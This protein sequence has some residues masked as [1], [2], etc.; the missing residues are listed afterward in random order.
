VDVNAICTGDG[1]F[2]FEEF[3]DAFEDDRDYTNTKNCR[4]RS[5]A[6]VAA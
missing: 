3:L 1:E 2:A 5:T 6:E 4:F